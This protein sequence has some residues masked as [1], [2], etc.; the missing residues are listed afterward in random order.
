MQWYYALNNQRQG[1]VTQAEFDKL[2]S[3]GIVKTDTLV[4]RQ[5]MAE[6]QPYAKVAATSGGVVPPIAAGGAVA[7]EA[8]DDTAICAASGKRYPKR[9][10]IQ[11]EGKW[12][13]AEHRD[14]YFQRMREGVAQPGEGPVPGPFGYGGFWRRF[15]ARFLDGLIQSVVMMPIGMALGLG[16]GS[17][18]RIQSGNVTQFIMVQVVIQLLG[19]AVGL[20]YEIFFVRKYDAT[21]GKMALGLKILRPDGTKLSIG[22]IVGRYFG[23]ILSSMILAIGYIMAAFDDEKRSLHDR[24]ADTRVIKTR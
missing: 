17:S 9:E 10:M 16:L 11:Y 1:P 8:T 22:R 20:S 3:D 18:A 6:W 2:V 15:V 13:S 24:L 4:W 14:T 5:G 7:A 12:I 23:S 21:P 19:F